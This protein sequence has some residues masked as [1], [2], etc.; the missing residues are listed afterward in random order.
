MIAFIIPLWCHR[1]YF[2]PVIII[3]WSDSM[4]YWCWELCVA[5]LD[6][7][8]LSQLFSFLF[9]A[10]ELDSKIFFTFVLWYISQGT[11][12]HRYETDTRQLK[13]CANCHVFLTVEH[14]IL[15]SSHHDFSAFVARYYSFDLHIKHIFLLSILS[16]CL[17]GS[18]DSRSDTLSNIDKL[19]AIY[20]S[21]S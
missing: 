4:S 14:F 2:S 19:L 21:S 6:C 16:S 7:L 10:S 13:P 9:I 17:I 8:L 11:L 20:E 18:L 1:Q 3:L 12:Q 15:C 5:P